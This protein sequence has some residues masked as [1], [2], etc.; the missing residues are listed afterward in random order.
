MP[1][2]TKEVRARARLVAKRM[3]LE[4][5]YEHQQ[6]VLNVVGKELGLTLKAAKPA[7]KVL[8]K[9]KKMPDCCVCL[10]PVQ[11]LAVFH[12]C[13]HRCCCESCAKRDEVETCPL[14]RTRVQAVVPRVYD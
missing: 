7:P 6:V 3:G 1:G 14:C 4:P 9:R 2:Q 11:H 5:W 13:G 8:G 10:E 12:P